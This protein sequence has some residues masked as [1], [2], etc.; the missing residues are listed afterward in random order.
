MRKK[1]FKPKIKQANKIDITET[2]KVFKHYISF[3][4]KEDKE[5]T[6]EYGIFSELINKYI[7]QE[8][9]LDIVEV[10]IARAGNVK[11]TIEKLG[12]RINSYIGVDPY[13]SGYDD[14]DIFSQ[15]S[16]VDMDFCYSYVLNKIDDDRFKLYRSSSE[17][18][19]PIIPDESIDAIYIDGDHTY[20]GVI[21]DIILWKDK[22]K[23]G[24]IIVGDDYPLFGGVKKAV[25]ESFDNFQLQDNCW[26]YINS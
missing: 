15:K 13:L 3:Y 17:F 7:S 6:W 4:E 11:D 26:F 12:N 22:V 24:G 16:Q 9:N 23:K 19:A 20:E 10:G 18:V 14:S 8:K 2:N 25:N 21:N 1:I 5:T